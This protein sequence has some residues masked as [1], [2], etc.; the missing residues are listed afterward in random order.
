MPVIYTINSSWNHI[1]YYC[2]KIWNA[3][4][5]CSNHLYKDLLYIL[6][7]SHI[8]QLLFTVTHFWNQNFH[9]I[10]AYIWKTACTEGLIL[11]P[12][13]T[14]PEWHWAMWTLG[15]KCLLNPSMIRADC[16]RENFPAVGV[17]WQSLKWLKLYKIF[18]MTELTKATAYSFVWS[19]LL[20]IYSFLM[21]VFRFQ[22]NVRANFLNALDQLASFRVDFDIMLNYNCQ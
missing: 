19:G 16:E 9:W 17:L 21:K 18:H 8:L 12:V 7:Y 11:G 15:F 1:L 5:F 22:I 13:I 14:V 20:N 2:Y 6:R 4:V 3:I 10:S